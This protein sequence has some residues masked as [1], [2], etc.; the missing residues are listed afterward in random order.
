MINGYPLLERK[1]DGMAANKKEQMNSFLQA[2]SDWYVYCKK[3]G[4]KV[5]GLPAAIKSHIVNC[6]EQN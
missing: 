6:N 4:K 1:Q 5:L 3:C 2:Q